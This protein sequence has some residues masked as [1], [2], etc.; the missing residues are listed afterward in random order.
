MKTF[1]EY[2]SRLHYENITIKH[3]MKFNPNLASK[4]LHD[5]TMNRASFI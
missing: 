1:I 4:I 2:E 5:S 3:Y